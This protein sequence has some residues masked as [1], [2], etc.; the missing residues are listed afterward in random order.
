MTK[1]EDPNIVSLD[2]RR[3]LRLA[4][5]FMSA[6]LGSPPTSAVPTPGWVG[7]EVKHLAQVKL[8]LAVVRDEPKPRERQLL[9]WARR[10]Q[11]SLMLVRMRD[12]VETIAEVGV[13]LALFDGGVVLLTR[14]SLFTTADAER[15]FLLGRPGDVLFRL[16][17]DGLVPTMSEPYRG[18][19]ERW[20]GIHEAERMFEAYVWNSRLDE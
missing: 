15:W 19:R 10:R 4:F 17:P 1:P 11:T 3:R 14:L 2:A 16:T 8:D 20:R 5:D 12:P 18:P 13:D 7:A 6:T 9:N